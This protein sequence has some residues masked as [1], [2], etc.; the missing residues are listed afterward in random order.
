MHK[1]KYE[2]FKEKTGCFQCGKRARSKAGRDG[3]TGWIL[4][5]GGCRCET[6]DEA[7]TNHSAPE[8][9]A[10]DPLDCEPIPS[11]IDGQFEVLSVLGKGGMGTVYKVRSKV[12]N[13]VIALKLIHQTLSKDAASKRFEHEAGAVS[14]LIIQ[15]LVAVYGPR[16]DKF[17]TILF[18]NGVYQR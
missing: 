1:S 18:V 10:K 7:K 6:T 17:R 15:N 9:Q 14:Q 12:T 16:Q 5:F 4:N 8:S 3:A 13:S 11:E 2:R